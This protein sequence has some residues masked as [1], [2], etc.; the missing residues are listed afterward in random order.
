MTRSLRGRSGHSVR[1][2]WRHVVVRGGR[3]RRR[4]RDVGLERAQRAPDLLPPRP[5]GDPRRREALLGRPAPERD[6]AVRRPLARA[7]R[8]HRHRPRRTRSPARSSTPAWPTRRSSNG[9]TTGYDEYAASVEDWTLER[10]EQ[11]T[12]VPA[13]A[14]RELAHAYAT[15]RRRAAL[16][17]TRHHR[18]PQRRRQRAVAL[19]PRAAHRPGRPVR[20]RPHSAPR[21]EQRAGRRRHG[22]AAEQAARLPGR[23][24]TTRPATKFETEW[25]ATRPARERLA[26][27]RDVRGDGARRAPLGLRDRREPGPVRG[28]RQ[29]A[30]ELLSSLDHLVV[31]D[32]YLTKTAELADVVLPGSRVVVR[33]RRHR[34]QLRATGAAGPQG[35]RPAR[36]GTR[37]HR[38]PARRSPRRLGHDWQLRRPRADLGR[39]APPLPDARRHVMA[40]TRGSSAASSGRASPRTRSEPP[41]LHGRLWADDPDERGRPAPFSVVDRRSAGRVAQ[42]RLPAPPHHRS[43]ARLVQHRR[44]VGRLPQPEPTRRDDRHL[45]RRRRA[46]RDRRRRDRARVVAPRWHRSSARPASIPGS[47]PGSCS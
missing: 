13:D 24:P 23:R 18:T 3:G 37:R 30:V 5:E 9:A 19:Q 44:A 38:H 34:H 16:L 45:A 33:I 28:R 8:R 40:A 29:P 47:G 17:D 43:P 1:S 26:P 39:A 2:R 6:R 7:P 32:I 35:A 41:F 12:G 22:C 20:R 36:R 25:G 10:G 15:R 27:H 4:H 11:V 31:L 42:R 46:T 21:P 14:I